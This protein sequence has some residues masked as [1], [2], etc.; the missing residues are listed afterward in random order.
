MTVIAVATVFVHP[1]HFA[2][3]HA[4]WLDEAWVAVLTRAP[5]HSLARLSSSAPI[6]FIGLLKLVPGS[7]LQRGRLV[8][9][10][11]SVLTAVAAY[12]LTRVLAWPRLVIAR[13]AA[14]VVAARRD[15]GADVARAQRPEAV[16]VDAFCALVLLALGVWCERGRPARRWCGWPSSRC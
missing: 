4:F 2:L 8:V 13:G 11:F 15:A 1:V 7:G 5:L 16:H 9:L 3:N 12:V 10:G 14:T 6:G